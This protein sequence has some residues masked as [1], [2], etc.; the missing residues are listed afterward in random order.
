M[1]RFVM[2]GLGYSFLIL[3][4]VGLFLPFLQGFLFLFVGLLILAKHATWA[5]RLLDWI[6]HR[7]PK[8]GSMIDK[9]EEVTDR[10]VHGTSDRFRGWWRRLG[11]RA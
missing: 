7:Y 9:A 6:R 3:G 10:W 5:Q 11:G 1:N 2:L 8:M 4:V